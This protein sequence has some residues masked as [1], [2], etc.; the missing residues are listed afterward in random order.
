MNAAPPY[1]AAAYAYAKGEDLASK[2]M[3]LFSALTGAEEAIFRAARTMR[4]RQN[5]LAEALAEATEADDA[6]CN[7]LR[8]VAAAGRL[9]ILGDIAR[10]YAELHA[11]ADGVLDIR[12]E[13]AH[14]MKLTARSEFDRALAKWSNKRVRVV[15]EEKA[16]LLGGVRVYV[17]DDVL[18]ASVR[19]RIDRL[20]AAIN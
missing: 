9:E 14:P 12:V 7:F 19:G 6:F 15:Y 16:A 1:A 10:C 17:K 11:E 4:G 3:R 2:W 8:V 20:S 5:A 18:D 13:T